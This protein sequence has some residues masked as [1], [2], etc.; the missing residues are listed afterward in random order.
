MSL[1]RTGFILFFFITT[2]FSQSLG[3]IHGMIQHQQTGE[4]ISFAQ[5]ILIESNQG[6]VADVAGNYS[7]ENIET[8]TKGFQVYNIKS[9]FSMENGLSLRVSVNNMFDTAYHEHLSRNF[10]KNTADSG[11]PLYE[12]GRNIIL[13]VAYKL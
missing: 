12:P 8:A 5:I 3:N 4:P 13:V 2:A 11:L 6:T 1:L 9:G 10:A 7:F